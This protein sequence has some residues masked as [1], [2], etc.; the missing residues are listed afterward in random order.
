MC[1]GSKA[2]ALH[3]PS[4]R[5]MVKFVPNSFLPSS[6]TTRRFR[7]RRCSTGVHAFWRGLVL[8]WICLT[9][10]SADQSGLFTYRVNGATVEITGYPT[11]ATGPVTIPAEIDGKPVVSIGFAAFESCTGITA[12]TIPSGVTS[13]DGHAFNRCSGITNLIIPSSVARI[14]RS[15]FGF[16][17]S[18]T[19]VSL[20]EGLSGLDVGVFAGCYSL[21]DVEIPSSVT[22][23][24]DSAFRG[25]RSLIS[26]M[27][28]PGVITIEQNAFS[29]CTSLSHLVLPSALT[30]LGRRAF[31]SCTGLTRISVPGGITILNDHV[32]FDCHALAEVSLPPGL[33]EIGRFAF[34]YTPSLAGLTIPSS[35]TR[36]SDYAFAYSALEEIVLPAGLTLIGTRA[37]ESCAMSKIAIPASVTTLGDFAF[38]GCYGLTAIDV[39]PANATYASVEGI[40][41]NTAIK[42]LLKCPARK[43]GPYAVPHGT[44]SISSHA[45]E[46]SNLDRISLP[47]SLVE[48]GDNAFWY[49]SMLVSITVS[50]ENTAFVSADGVLFDAGKT[51][52]IRYPAARTGEYEVPPSVSFLA[53]G[54][55]SHSA[56]L[57]RVAVGGLVS[58]IRPYT[59]FACPALR[60]VSLPAS[61]DLIDSNAFSGC[62]SLTH[63]SLPPNLNTLAAYAFANCHTLT[64]V[65]V[66]STV[67]QIGSRAFYNCPRLTSALF[68]GD[69]PGSTS[70]DA[71]SAAAAAFTVYYVRHSERFTSPI[72]IGY[73]SQE[74]DSAAVPAASWLMEHGWPPDTD[75]TQD[76]NGKGVSLFLAYALDLDPRSD[77]SA[78]QPPPVFTETTV[79]LEF[80]PARSELR[81]RVETS[82]ELGKWTSDGVQ[83]LPAGP[84]G[85]VTATVA[86][87]QPKKFLRLMIT[88]E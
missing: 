80:K 31:S 70:H 88:D 27:L 72:W 47:S 66:P 49:C 4:A 63:F 48:I 30:S 22:R 17:T 7:M 58:T 82:T 18:L 6:V 34:A 26:L 11:E 19:Q 8:C 81:Y 24:G 9:T 57:T 85:T 35:V 62:G 71:F 40:L 15:S 29:G 23:I 53:E 67:Y 78:S 74:M 32:F 16:C 10:L 75:L 77:L 45:F 39:H 2:A 28:P 65:I 33:V 79:G 21:T 87:D 20:P 14:G 36:I 3:T 38:S 54:A 83:Q 64:S 37:F 76:V 5:G 68:L 41:F 44:V 86:R 59:F 12:V 61:V 25:C 55:F 51:T 1:V 84:D 73:P 56:G 52:L 13:L 42:A 60:Q 50:P 69:A 46:E 43:S